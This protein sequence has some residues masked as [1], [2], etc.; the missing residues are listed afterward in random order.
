[1]C[2]PAD[3][4]H[5][6]RS[7]TRRRRTLA[8]SCSGRFWPRFHQVFASTQGSSVSRSSSA[9]LRLTRSAGRRRPQSF[10]TLGS[11]SWPGSRA[12]WPSAPPPSAAPTAGNRPPSSPLSSTPLLLLIGVEPSSGKPSSVFLELPHVAGGTVIWVAGLGIALTAPPLCSSCPPQER[13]QTFAGLSCAGVAADARRLRRR[14]RSLSR[15][16]SLHQLGLARPRHEPARRSSILL[17]TW[18]LSRLSTSRSTPCRSPSTRPTVRNYFSSSRKSL[19]V[20]HV[21]IWPLNTHWRWRSPL[22][23]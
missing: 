23:W 14:Q 10:S 5:R 18:E 13:H 4:R 7:S 21:H 16:D 6:P 11:A 3:Y 2:F 15:G 8:F 9:C 12:S 19:E 22:I 1:M 17:S 20:H